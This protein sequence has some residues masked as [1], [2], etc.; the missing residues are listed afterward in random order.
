M[1]GCRVGVGKDC[2]SL[3][4]PKVKVACSPSLPCSYSVDMCGWGMASQRHLCPIPSQELV[5]Q[6]EKEEKCFLSLFLVLA[7]SGGCEVKLLAENWR[8]FWQWEQLQ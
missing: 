8:T 2:L 5:R 4:K 1:G 3:W 7:G 6:Q